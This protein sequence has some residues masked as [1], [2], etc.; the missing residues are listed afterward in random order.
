MDQDE[1]F[2][3]HLG[4]VRDAAGTER[5]LNWNLAHW[6]EHGFGLWMLREKEAGVMIGR[7]VLRH[8]EVD[9]VDEVETG[10]GFLPEFWGRGLATEIILACLGLGHD[11]L[12]LG[13]IVAITV[14]ANK[15]SQRVL[16]K[17]GLEYE[18]EIVHN[19]QT[20][21]LF[22]NRSGAPPAGQSSE[23]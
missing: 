21:L 10:Y 7:A 4:G 14:P 12:G 9:G 3:A 2:M 5:Y 6:S 8:L 11:Q 16:H 13:S 19:G 18:R 17:A 20:H 1:R 23:S 22:R 15:A